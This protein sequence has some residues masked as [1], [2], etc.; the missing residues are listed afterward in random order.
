MLH[1]EENPIIAAVRTRDGFEKA[2]DCPCDILFLL[3]AN[4]LTLQ[5]DIRATHQKKKLLFVHVDIAEGIG[6]DAAGIQHLQR[7]CADGIISTRGNMIKT[8][9]ENGLKTVHRVFLLDSHSI[10][11]AFDQ[12]A[13]CHPDMVELMPGVIPKMIARFSERLKTPIIAG[14]LIDKKNEIIQALSAG[15]KAVSTARPELWNQ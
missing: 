1:L 3:C 9:R 2:L 14:G 10:E 8:A 6:R 11:T 5:E 15:A 7:L 4:I 13:S 12:I